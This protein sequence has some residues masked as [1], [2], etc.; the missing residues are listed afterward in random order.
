[1]LLELVKLNDWKTDKNGDAY[2]VAVS[3]EYIDSNREFQPSKLFLVRD[4]DIAK[5]IA[6]GIKSNDF[7]KADVKNAI[8]E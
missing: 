2:C 5:E 7:I 6:E 4:K 3:K 8:G 1:M